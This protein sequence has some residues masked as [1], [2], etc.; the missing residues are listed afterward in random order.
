MCVCV[1]LLFFLSIKSLF[2]IN[3]I[4]LYS[5]FFYYYYIILYYKY[6]DYFWRVLLLFLFFFFYDF[7][8]FKLISIWI[9][10]LIIIIIIRTTDTSCYYIFII[11]KINVFLNF[12]FNDNFILHLS[13]ALNFYIEFFKVQKFFLCFIY[14]KLSLVLEYKIYRIIFFK[15]FLFNFYV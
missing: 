9:T 15:I 11:T 6:L 4:F 3:I 10:Y 2:Q 13:P 5:N 1:F 12:F 7:I 8:V 14:N